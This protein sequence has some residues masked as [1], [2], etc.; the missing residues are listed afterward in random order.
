MHPVIDFFRRLTEADDWP[1]R[2]HCGTWSSFHGWLYVGSDLAIW[3]AYFLIPLFLFRFVTEKPD[4]P[5][6]RIFWWFIAFILF[7]GATHLIDAVLFWYPAYR[8]SALLLFG[9]AVASWCTVWAL[10]RFYPQ[11][12]RLRTTAEFD[13]EL[14]RRDRLEAELREAQAQLRRRADELEAKNR[15]LEQFAYITSHDLQE[16]LRTITNYTGWLEQHGAEGRDPR[17]R[18]ALAFLSRSSE[19]LRQQITGL[20][21]HSRIGRQADPGP[22]SLPEVVDEARERLGAAFAESGARLDH[23]DLPT[24]T[25]YRDALV[26]LF[27]NLIGNAIKFRHPGREPRIRI[28][29]EHDGDRW[30]LDVIDNG[31]GVDPE[32]RDRIFQLFQRL[33][34]QDEIPGIGIGLAHARK[35]ADLHGGAIACLDGEDG[36]GATF[37]FLLP[38]PLPS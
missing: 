22:V 29:A 3:G 27:Q 38:Q 31:I 8:L 26:L 13:A 19:R 20:L 10:Y 21:Q 30:I 34:A 9:T 33:H 2:W 15:E 7:C 18:Q 36:R 35:I 17:E 37:R 16:P 1:A 12:I 11:A 6:P 23:G 32:Y 28:R 25:G 5:V 14:R 4:L 24:V